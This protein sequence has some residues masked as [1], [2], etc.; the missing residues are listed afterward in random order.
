MARLPPAGAPQKA[1]NLKTFMS[2]HM[3][4]RLKALKLFVHV[5]HA[6]SFSRA[7]PT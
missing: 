1:F 6:G 5:A 4:D 2:N 7:G 3:N